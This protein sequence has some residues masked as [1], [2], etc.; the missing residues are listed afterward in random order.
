M[1]DPGLPAGRGVQVDDRV[2][3]GIAAP[4]D[5]PVEQSPAWTVEAVIAGL[6][7]GFDKQPPVQRHAHS[8]EAR[9]FEKI[10][11]VLADINIAKLRPET[12]RRRGPN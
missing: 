3:T 10:D 4:P 7:T 1:V 2:Q 5:E 8:V 6:R 9:R 11:I 12:I